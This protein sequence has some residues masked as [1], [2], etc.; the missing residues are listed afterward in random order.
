[1]KITMRTLMTAFSSLSLAALFAS[2]T[3]AQPPDRGSREGRPGGRLEGARP[4]GGREAGPGSREAGPGGRGFGPGMREGGMRPDPAVMG[5]MM[6]ERFDKDGDQKL[7]SEELVAAIREL[8]LIAM[9]SGPGGPG[10]PGGGGFPGGPGFGGGPGAGG[11][12]MAARMLEQYDADGD[13]KL[14]GDEIPERMR[15]GMARIDTNGDGAI[16]KAEL[17]QMMRN[18]GGGDRPTRERGQEGGE[19]NR[20]PR[21]PPVED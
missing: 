8:R 20:T 10:G 1:M 16:D 4:E 9:P 2:I 17:E 19:G 12:Q 15:Q 11:P 18:M 21:R 6:M 14:T 3:L 13:G 5:K 7:N